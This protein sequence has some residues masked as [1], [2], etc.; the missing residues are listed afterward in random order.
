[1]TEQTGIQTPWYWNEVDPKTATIVG[2]FG[3][4]PLD[5]FSLEKSVADRASRGFGLP[6]EAVMPT[7]QIISQAFAEL[8]G[9]EYNH[10]PEA[11]QKT[12]IDKLRECESDERQ[13]VLS[14]LGRLAAGDSA[15]V[16]ELTKIV[17]EK[18]E[19]DAPYITIPLL[20]AL[21][22][23]AIHRLAATERGPG[24]L[25]WAHRRSN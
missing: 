4:V 16:A 7:Q 1:M 6:S 21:S 25:Y 17:G 13:E 11:I 19:G 18:I 10:D 2:A 24:L 15:P 3:E 9:E 20:T 12:I 14:E 5:I 22:T 8:Q 23:L